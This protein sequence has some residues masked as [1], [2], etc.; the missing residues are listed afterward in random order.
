[1][2][3]F[4]AMDQ[5]MAIKVFMHSEQAIKEPYGPVNTAGWQVAV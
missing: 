1:M 2:F 4:L 5:T 3:C